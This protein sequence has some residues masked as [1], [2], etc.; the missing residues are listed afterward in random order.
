MRIDEAR[1]GI[2]VGDV[3]VV[4]ESKHDYYS[5]THRAISAHSGPFSPLFFSL[6]F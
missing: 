1:V 6:C 4:V 3:Y 2:D 5:F